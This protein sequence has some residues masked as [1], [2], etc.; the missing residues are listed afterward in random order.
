MRRGDRHRLATRLYRKARGVEQ[1]RNGYFHTAGAAELW[2]PCAEF[3]DYEISN[4]A[5]V[6]RRRAGNVL[7]PWLIR[8]YPAVNLR[9]DGR[10]FKKLVARLYGEVF[11]GLAPGQQINH[12][13]LRPST[14]AEIVH[15]NRG[16]A[17]HT[18]KYK[19]VSR[20]GRRWFACIQ[21]HGKTRSLGSFD[22]EVAA[23]RAYDRAA[24]AAWGEFAFLNFPE[25]Q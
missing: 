23:A 16:R 24:A 20:A 25:T 11:L 19:G 17:Y 22:S 15:A 13:N 14:R 8:G 12:R 9:R 5:R 7:H 6:R 21:I 3:P 4:L 1:G 18:S 2:R 10:T